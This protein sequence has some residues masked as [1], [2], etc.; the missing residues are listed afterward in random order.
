MSAWF[1][2]P[3]ASSREVF[4]YRRQN[5]GY[6][7]YSLGVDRDDDRGRPPEN[8]EYGRSDWRGNGDLRLDAYFADMLAPDADMEEIAEDGESPVPG[9]IE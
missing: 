7:L 5:G 8:D 1:A 9:A 2:D 4:V 6:L 3:F